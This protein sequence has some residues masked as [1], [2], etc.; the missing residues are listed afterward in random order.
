MDVLIC[1][2]F[3][4]TGAPIVSMKKKMEFTEFDAATNL[5]SGDLRDSVFQIIKW[6][7]IPKSVF[8][9]LREKFIRNKK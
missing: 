9:S 2:I 7:V 3:P 4:K 1:D 5:L 8:D 6:F